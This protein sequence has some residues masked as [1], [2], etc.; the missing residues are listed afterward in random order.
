M[1]IQNN[2]N[3][4][5]NKNIPNGF[6]LDILKEQ[7]FG[8][9]ETDSF[10]VSDVES[11]FPEAGD[12]DYSIANLSLM[13]IVD[14]EP[15]IINSVVNLNNLSQV[16]SL[17]LTNSILNDIESVNGGNS[18][19]FS[20]SMVNNI[21][22]TNEN[23]GTSGSDIFGSIINKVDIRTKSST[24]TKSLYSDSSIGTIGY[25]DDVI[26]FTS[27]SCVFLNSKIEN[28]KNANVNKVGD[29]FSIL[30]TLL[31]NSD[32]T[33]DELT[34]TEDIDNMVGF[35]LDSDSLNWAL[36]QPLTQ[37]NKM[38]IKADVLVDGDIRTKNSGVINSAQ[39][40]H[41]FFE[42]DL[43]FDKAN[44]NTASMAD[45]KYHRDGGVFYFSKYAYDTSQFTNLVYRF[46][47]LVYSKI[48]DVFAFNVLSDNSYN[49]FALRHSNSDYIQVGNNVVR[50]IFGDNTVGSVGNISG[51]ISISNLGINNIMRVINNPLS[52][53][54]APDVAT[55]I[56]SA[57]DYQAFRDEVGGELTLSNTHTSVAP[58]EVVQ[59][60]TGGDILVITQDG[61]T[62][63]YSNSIGYSLIS[64]AI[65]SIS[66]ITPYNG[67]T[68]ALAV[69]SY[70]ELFHYKTY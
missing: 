63:G 21:L 25:D 61:V 22:Y 40:E 62:I 67:L 33:F 56:S 50:V 69:D 26:E 8:I 9:N 15:Y 11:I 18:Y 10:I 52:F 38:V 57:E 19:S 32:I 27:N 39:K 47:S 45:G 70:I 20:N 29:S 17:S 30:N 44:W 3:R 64:G 12:I 43:T 68:V 28:I 41:L 35:N 2:I 54:I 5:E 60:F 49:E 53:K 37:D 24:L 46:Y 16:N 42:E 31:Y 23:S 51:N 7:Y 65:S 14:S 58:L 36:N 1:L 13:G 4:S 34:L 6:F 55:V 59:T 66:G 48:G